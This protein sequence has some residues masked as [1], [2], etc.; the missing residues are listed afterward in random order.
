MSKLPIR[1]AAGVAAL[2]LT[3]SASAAAWSVTARAAAATTLPG[4]LYA[5]SADSPSDAWAVGRAITTPGVAHTLTMHWNGQAWSRVKSP[6][7]NKNSNILLAVSA[8]SSTDA[9]A[10]GDVGATSCE[11]SCENSLIEHW[12]GTAWSVTKAPKVGNLDQLNGVEARSPTDV[13]AVGRDCAANCKPTSMGTEVWDA[14][15]LNWNG[16]AWTQVPSPEPNSLVNVLTAVNA[17]SATDVW[18]VGY[19]GTGTLTEQWNGS[20]WSQVPSPDPA[21][22]TVLDGVS[23]ISSTDVW[24]VGFYCPKGCV[25]GPQQTAA[26]NWNGTAWS[27]VPTP[28]RKGAH[29]DELTGVSAVSATDVWA[30][31]T[32]SGTSKGGGTQIFSWNGTAWSA[33]PTHGPTGAEVVLSGVSADSATDAWAVGQTITAGGGTAPLRLHWNGTAWSRS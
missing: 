6:N 23:V 2:A 28:N 18:A 30:A 4:T 8:D 14:L 9:W 32:F 27:V 25:A 15:I 7:P 22:S 10:V 13:W 1:G 33:V 3:L 20:A 11:P 16:T 12:N 5:V 19:D 24:A 21:Q 26:M 29:L 31:G 17:D